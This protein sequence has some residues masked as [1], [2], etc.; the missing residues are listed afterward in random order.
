MVPV[1]RLPRL[2][3]AVLAAV[4]VPAL[5]GCAALGLPQVPGVPLVPVVSESVDT[6]PV[7]GVSPDLALTG[8]VASADGYSLSLPAGWTAADLSAEDGLALADLLGAVE[9]TLGAAARAGLEADGAPRLS[10]AALDAEATSLGGYG[11]GVIIATM[12][13]RGMEKTAARSLVESLLGQTNL[14]ADPIHTVEELPAGD[15]HHYEAFVL[16]DTPGVELQFDI[17]VFRVGGDSFV[18]AAVA[19]E[20]EFSAAQPSFDAILK[21]LRFG[22]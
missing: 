4:A 18:V 9:P 1:S 6:S 13:T 10:L 15:A 12:R 14:A 22:V 11:P 5:S 3:F 7:P 19:P 17:Y 21:S 16:A 8:T 20:A 2:Q